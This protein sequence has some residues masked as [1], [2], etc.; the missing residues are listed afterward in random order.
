MTQCK[1]LLASTHATETAAYSSGAYITDPLRFVS[2]I[3][4]HSPIL[5]VGGDAGGGHTKLGITYCANGVMQ[6]AALLVYDG[7]DS[8]EL[9]NALTIP[10]LTP[11]TGNSAH[12]P[13]IFAVLQHLIDTRSAFLNGD[14]P[15]I[16][17]VLGLK[18]ASSRNP[19]P[20]CI[21][22]STILIRPARYRTARDKHSIHPTNHALLTIVPERI[23]PTPLHLFLG[24][25]NR[26]IF[27]VYSELVGE[28]PVVETMRNIKTVHSA[29]CGGITD[30]HQ[31]NGPE[32]TKW[33]K[34]KCCNTMLTLALPALEMTP[35]KVALLSSWM[36]QLYTRLLHAKD[37][38]V[39]DLFV[40]KS[41]VDIIQSS[42]RTHTSQRV[43]PQLH[44]LR[45]AVE[46]AERYRFLGRASEA[47]IES[48]HVRFNSFFHI[49]HRN[50]SSN[51]AERLRRSL[52]D[53]SLH[54]MQPNLAF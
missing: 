39:A 42:W 27:D 23:V 17:A 12:M 35:S 1:K 28:V 25:S 8:W 14:W 9:M 45:H 53:A 43:F 29:G 21:V 48:F 32:I 38:N 51:T 49:R 33:L 20:I 4:S 6:F 34:K 41:F 31:L 11:L 19:C 26:I 16:N 47:Q 46:F 37:W 2:A 22:P 18:S 52:A 15:F 54:A 40:F 36:N 50:M 13:H 7:T 3:A 5:A 30:V 24:I 10:H 44:M